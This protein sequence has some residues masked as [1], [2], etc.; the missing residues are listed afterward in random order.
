MIA[1][2]DCALVLLA[3]GQSRRFGGSKLDAD[4]WGHP[5]GLHVV[6]RLAEVPF[7]RRVAVTGRCRINYAAH[8]FEVAANDDPTVGMGR[9]LGLGVARA[10]NVRAILVV[11]ADMPCVSAGHVRRLLEAGS[12]PPA[13]VASSDGNTLSPPALFG[14]AWFGHL[15]TAEG[16]AG[17]RTLIRKAHAVVAEPG[18]LIDVDTAETLDRLRANA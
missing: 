4:L 14:S 16:D 13:L 6:E 17:A 9:S 8:G 12:G 18:E 11:L 15:R 1:A 7:G 3:A 2:E 10:S 5:L